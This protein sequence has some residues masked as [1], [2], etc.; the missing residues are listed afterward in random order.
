M[1]HPLRGLLTA[2]FFGAFNDN[3]WKYIILTLA[4]RPIIAGTGG[5]GPESTGGRR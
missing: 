4:I 3:A 1:K 5:S 2:Q